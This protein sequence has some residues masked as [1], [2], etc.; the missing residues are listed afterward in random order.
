ME[1]TNKQLIDDIQN[2][3]NRHDGLQATS[4]N[5]AFLGFMDRET[6]LEI[7]AS[8]LKQHENITQDNLEWL[9]QFKTI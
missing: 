5:P 4:I 2:L 8:L 9:Q 6:L 1:S 3:L 7:I